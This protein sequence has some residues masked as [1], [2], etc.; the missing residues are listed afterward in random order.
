[1]R[2]VGANGGSLKGLLSTEA[3]K[4]LHGAGGV[5]KDPSAAMGIL[6]LV[7]FI[8][9]WEQVCKLRAN[10]LATEASSTSLQTTVEEAYKQ[11]LLPYHGWVTQKAFQMA[12][13]AS[14]TWE[15]VLPYFA[16]SDDVFR[17]DVDGF[18]LASQ[19]LKLRV[20]AALSQ[21]DLVDVRKS[22]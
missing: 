5:L 3:R 6:W 16:D 19:E 17:Q 9:F 14:P 1:M 12:F 22:V 10:L 11:C 13:Q 4:G 15:S 18:V 7:R 2:T 8:A 20:M 21:F